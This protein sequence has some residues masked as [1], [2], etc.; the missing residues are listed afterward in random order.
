MKCYPKVILIENQ[1]LLCTKM[2]ERVTNVSWQNSPFSFLQNLRRVLIENDL[3]DVTLISDD[4]KILKSHKLILSA[5][6][7]VF[8]H[9]IQANGTTN[10]NIYLR[11]IKYTE[12]EAI[13]KFMYMGE[14]SIPQNKLQEFLRV[15][16]DLQIKDIIYDKSGIIPKNVV[17]QIPSPSVSPSPTN[18][19]LSKD[20]PTI[21][22]SDPS[23][24]PKENVNKKGN[25]ETTNDQAGKTCKICYQRV[26]TLD[27]LKDHL[28]TIHLY[29]ECEICKRIFQNEQY[30][31][32]HNDL[33]H[34]NRVFPCE[35]CAFRGVTL[36]QLN[37]HMNSTHKMQ[38]PEDNGSDDA[39]AKTLEKVCDS[40]SDQNKTQPESMIMDIENTKEKSDIL[41]VEE[42]KK[43]DLCDFKIVSN[44]FN[45]HMQQVHG[46]GGSKFDCK[47][48]AF[49]THR[50]SYLNAHMINCHEGG[51]K[52]E[53]D[54]CDHKSNDPSNARRHKRI[55]HEGFR[56]PCKMC[57]YKGSTSTSLKLHMNSYHKTI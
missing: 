42:V 52:Y 40:D 48:C 53:C 14:T 9:I 3:C 39:S 47:E 28:V 18:L 7:P 10:P 43:C 35:E 55:M 29:L 23:K 50:K 32:Q 12:I 19:I 30:L 37:N 38:S 21:G 1:F 17:P 51:T 22:R 11:G 20:T 56:Y 46:Q 45:T 25:I 26:S 31:K 49:S 33:I 41:E 15:A 57:N 24:S 36:T 44:D 4:Q 54:Q 27:A 8:K 13:L 6:S 34:N 2:T 16:A 5:C